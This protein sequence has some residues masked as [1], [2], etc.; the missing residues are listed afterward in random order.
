[1]SAVMLLE[2]WCKG[3]D[4]DPRKALLIV[5]I[6]VECEEAEIKE[7]VKAGLQLLCNYRMLGRMFR[8]EDSSKAVFIELAEAVDFSAIPSQI[9]GRGGAWEVVVQPRNPDDEFLT[10][11][12]YFLKG[13]GRRMVDVAQTLGYGTATEGMEP[14]VFPQVK[15][16]VLQ[17]LKESMWYRKL[18]VFSGS[19]FP[20][21]GE[22]SFEVWLEQVN[23]IMKVWQVSEIEKRRR[24]LESLRG[25]A[26]SI[27]R[28]LRAHNDTMTAEQCLDALKQ[29]FGSKE[30]HR[31]AQFK[32]LQAFQM[33]REKT[34]V[35]LLRLEPL[36]QKAVQHSPMS[37]RSTDL[38]RLKHML[39]R[40]NLTST[41]RG[42]LEI[43]DQRGCPPTF[44]ELIKL[45]RDEEEW[46]TTLAVMKEKERNGARSPRASGRQ[47]IAE[48]I[49]SMP[50][51]LMQAG[52]SCESST[53]TVQEG[54]VP[55]VKR[56]RQPCGSAEGEGHN[57]MTYP[58]ME[59]QPPV[60]EPAQFVAQVSGNEAGAGALS[61]PKP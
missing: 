42:K 39:A 35:F 43:L 8:R 16:I 14:G 38:I 31:T 29:I 20:G 56:R 30:D 53:Q 4:L 5:G 60:M 58:K 32:F 18:K 41:L 61:H 21:P 51:V 59:N 25:P 19:T 15:P 54:A 50:Q 27:I 24:L 11:L 49:F 23:E 46:E 52:P 55:S 36:L 28:V 44:L 48:A 6:P 2:D 13:E 3:M 34:S 1:M 40:A 22:E 17:P 47:G 7:T 26:L 10:R 37:V 45:I 12:S 33:S 57:Q 9:P